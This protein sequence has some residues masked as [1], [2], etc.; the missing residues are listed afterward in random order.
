MARFRMFDFSGIAVSVSVLLFIVMV[1]LPGFAQAKTT[2]KLAHVCAESDI[3]QIQSVKFKELVE[4]RTD[5]AVEIRIYPNKQLGGKESDLINMVQ[6]GT[7]GLAT[8]TCGPISTFV[9]MF[10][11]LDMPFL[12]KS[13]EHA[14]HVLDG[15]IGDRFLQS[16]A[17]VNIAGLAFGERGFRNVSNN[18]RP[19]VTPSDLKG[20]K[21]RVMQSPVYIETFKALGANPIP[22]GWGDVYTALQQG[23]IDAQENPPWVIDAF[24]IYEVQKYYSLTGHSYAGNVIM[25]NEALM[26][27][28][29][30]DVQQILVEAAREA[31]AYERKVNNDGVTEVLDRLK[32]K[33][34]QINDLDRAPFQKMIKSVYAEAYQKNPEW[35]GIVEE[36]QAVQ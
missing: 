10:G 15:P 7:I 20:I 4:K 6:M 3:F 36:I 30:P 25:M 35:K 26:K 24:K 19:I 9:P 1:S 17:N 8:I 12:F 32:S 14:Y 22:M 23:T 5:G 16:L 34:M 2:I 13:K 21:I 33:G 31:S 29:S 27:G 18:L 28:F 11:I